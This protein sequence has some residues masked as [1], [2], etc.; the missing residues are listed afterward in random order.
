MTNGC[1]QREE[2]DIQTV[3][4]AEMS[5]ALVFVSSPSSPPLG[6]RIESR[7]EEGREIQGSRYGGLWESL[8]RISRLT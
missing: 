4:G 5:A 3:G 7:V 1:L 6:N 8:G 2:I